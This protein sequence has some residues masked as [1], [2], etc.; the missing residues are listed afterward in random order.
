MM[1]SGIGAR[2]TLALV[3]DV[4]GVRR[5]VQNVCRPGP[6]GSEPPYAGLGELWFETFE[7][8]AAAL[9]SPEW[10][11]VIDDA[12]FH[13][14]QCGDCRMGRRAQC[15]LS[16]AGSPLRS[17]RALTLA[18]RASGASTIPGR[19]RRSPGG[20]V[21]RSPARRSTGNRRRV[22]PR[23]PLQGH[24]RGAFASLSRQEVMAGSTRHTR[25]AHPGGYDAGW[26]GS[27]GR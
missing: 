26:D 24:R 7:D 9:D 10:R 16:V 23:R 5:Y 22:S 17:L 15:A 3:R 2:I 19:L 12:R 4:P 11:A 21:G 13:G 1:L 25:A 18:G 20:G 6:D 14:A 27:T 8:A